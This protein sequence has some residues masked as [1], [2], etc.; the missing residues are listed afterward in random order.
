MAADDEKTTGS[1]ARGSERPAARQEPAAKPPVP[2][3]EPNKP[4]E[5]P[6]EP[7]PK[8]TVA[9]LLASPNM[10]GD[11]VS[12]RAIAGAFY[13]L[14]T[15]VRSHTVADA[16]RRVDEWLGRPQEGFETGEDEG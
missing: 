10:L 7:A 3:P 12:V 2:A 11:G 16:Q 1:G 8:F 5:T 4:A 6:V 15:D 9:E 13:G 14:K